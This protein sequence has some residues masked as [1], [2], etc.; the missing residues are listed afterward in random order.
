MTHSEMPSSPSAVGA[1]V[2]LRPAPSGES[3]PRWGH[4]DG[5]QVGLQVGLHPLDGPRGLLRIYAPYLGHD[6]D[7][8]V[9][10]I[11]V[12][13]VP[14]GQ[15]E[16][17]YSE[18]EKSQY[19]GVPG[20]RFW[21]ADDPS[22]PTSDAGER[23]ARGVVRTVAGVE[24]LR[25][26]I[27]IEPFR[28]GAEVAVSV[29][30]R[31]D[32][33]HEIELAAIA[34]PASAPLAQCVLS[35]TMG[36]WARL[37]RLHLADHTV[38]ARELWPAYRGTDFADHARFGVTELTAENGVV[39]VSATPDED[40]PHDAEYA[41]GTKEH[42]HYV[43]RRAVQSWRAADP[44]PDLVAQVNGRYTYWMSTAPIPG[45]IAFENF[46]LV[47]PFRSGRPL[48]FSVEPLDP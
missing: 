18:L 27:L 10:F 20:L 42:W 25:I 3:E 38:T 45:G 7:R 1:Y 46:E 36:N 35:A 13:P 32:R 41:E 2:W 22:D 16:R 23:P 40:A 31:A 8:L 34:G 9:N 43:G 24:H 47:E 12:E 37:R 19:D 39:S 6:R 48:V 11:A 28:N 5:L 26:W 4:P 44:H 15:S 33:P 21:S 30:F 17:G 14:E 29:T